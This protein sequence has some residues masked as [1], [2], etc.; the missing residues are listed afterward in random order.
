MRL[1]QTEVVKTALER[2]PERQRAAV[3]LR[4]FDELPMRAVAEI[5]GVNEVTARTQVFRGLRKLGVYLK[6]K[7][8]EDR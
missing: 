3:T 2:L 7:R 6:A 8:G 1:E 5:L 4:F